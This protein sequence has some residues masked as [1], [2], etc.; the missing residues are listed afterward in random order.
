MEEF[1]RINNHN[2]YG[3]LSGFKYSKKLSNTPLMNKLTDR[4]GPEFARKIDK[5]A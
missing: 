5:D 2:T 4:M 1:V 3:D